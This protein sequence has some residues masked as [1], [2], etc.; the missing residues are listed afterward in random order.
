MQRYLFIIIAILLSSCYSLPSG[1]EQQKVLLTQNFSESYVFSITSWLKQPEVTIFNYGSNLNSFAQGIDKL[2]SLQVASGLDWSVWDSEEIPF[3]PYTK[4]SPAFVPY[5]ESSVPS[6]IEKALAQAVKKSLGVSPVFIPRSELNSE[7]PQWQSPVHDAKAIAAAKGYDA[8]AVIY[9]TPRM[10]FNV[11][12]STASRDE[13]QFVSL[14]RTETVELASLKTRSAS[15][16]AYEVHL[17]MRSV[18]EDL[19]MYNRTSYYTCG[20]DDQDY[21]LP[22]GLVVKRKFKQTLAQCEQ[23]IYD[24][25]IND[26]VT[27]IQDLRTAP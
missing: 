4:R 13:K 19:L 26:I 5:N 6:T 11:A 2:A 9:L 7:R 16:L 24:A 20:R 22:S 15:A 14:D 25:V 1:K 17:V 12:A 8:V 3:T 23:Q 10:H 18:G 21:R 27:S